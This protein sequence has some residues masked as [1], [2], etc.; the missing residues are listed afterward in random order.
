MTRKVF[1]SQFQCCGLAVSGAAAA[2]V[3]LCCGAAVLWCCAVSVRSVVF[4]LLCLLRCELHAFW[5]QLFLG[6]TAEGMA[7][8]STDRFSGTS[9]CHSAALVWRN[10]FKR[11]FSAG[12]HRRRVVCP[13]RTG[14]S[15]G[16]GRESRSPPEVLVR[17]GP[18]SYASGDD[19]RRRRLGA[20]S[21]WLPWCLSALV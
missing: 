20:M 18:A 12:V 6:N 11:P 17:V 3:L 8:S 10:I 4:S 5:L 19:W 15:T 7:K 16:V 1:Y 2:A 13:S 21:N 14:R 9:A